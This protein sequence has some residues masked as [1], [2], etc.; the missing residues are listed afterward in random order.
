MQEYLI[1]AISQYDALRM[2]AQPGICPPGLYWANE[3]GKYI[4]IDNSTGD[5]WVEEFETLQE[6]IRWLRMDGEDEQ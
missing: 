6:C 4:G 1:Q 2:A 5:A 3:S